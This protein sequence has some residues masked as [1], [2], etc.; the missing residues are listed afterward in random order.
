MNKI[1]T[2]GEKEYRFVNGEKFARGDYTTET[3]FG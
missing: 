2:I 1:H 3:I